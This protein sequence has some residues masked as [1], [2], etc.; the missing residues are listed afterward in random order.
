MGT[1]LFLKE[2]KDVP[3]SMEMR[4]P[5]GINWPNTRMTPKVRKKL[6]PSRPIPLTPPVKAIPTEARATEDMNAR[7]RIINIL[8]IFSGIVIISSPF[9]V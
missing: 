1:S 2:E 5:A 8:F 4:I 6:I 7:V 9:T 3:I